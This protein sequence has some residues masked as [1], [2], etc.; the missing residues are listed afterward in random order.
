MLKKAGPYTELPVAYET[1]RAKKNLLKWSL[2][3]FVDIAFIKS[4][5]ALVTIDMCLFCDTNF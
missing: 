4:F 2:V 3:C 1:A 5:I